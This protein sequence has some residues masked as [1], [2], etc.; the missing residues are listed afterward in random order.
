[1]SE[2]IFM[3]PFQQI[4]WYWPSR[5]FSILL[6]EKN[7]DSLLEHLYLF[8]ILVFLRLVLLI[9]IPGE[10]FVLKDLS[11]YDVA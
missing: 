5:K 9:L 6:I 8:V 4:V 7:L 10:H 11:F 1:M 3:N 2:Q